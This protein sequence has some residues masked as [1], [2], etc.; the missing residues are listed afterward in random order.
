MC[1]EEQ[2]SKYIYIY[3]YMYYTYIYIYILSTYYIYYLSI[4]IYILSIYHHTPPYR[5]KIISAPTGAPLRHGGPPGAVVT[6]GLVSAACHGGQLSF[7]S[8]GDASLVGDAW[9]DSGAMGY[10]MKFLFFFWTGIFFYCS[11]I[12]ECYVLFKWYLRWS[13]WICPIFGCLVKLRMIHRLDLSFFRESWYLGGSII[14]KR[15]SS[16]WPLKT[17]KYSNQPWLENIWDV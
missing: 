9:R 12:F 8:S 2:D 10:L 5:S 7:Q 1:R 3:I 16:Y 11:D 17:T 6:G 4:Y 14:R 13:F 15:C